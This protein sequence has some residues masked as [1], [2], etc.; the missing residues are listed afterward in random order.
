MTLTGNPSLVNSNFDTPPDNPL[1]LLREWL[2]TADQLNISEPRS[3]ILSTVDAFNRP[4]S[5]VVLIK[6]CDANG[7][8]FCSSQTSAKGKD[9][10]QNP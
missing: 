3:M 6:K 5:R 7:I 2:A 4:S 1:I 8:I 9:L 10:A